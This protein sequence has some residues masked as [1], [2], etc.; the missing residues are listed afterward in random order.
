MKNYFNFTVKARQMVPYFFYMIVLVFGIAVV[1]IM[2]GLGGVDEM[3]TVDGDF[4]IQLLGES[5][6]SLLL[7]IGIMLLSLNMLASILK[8]IV[9][10]EQPF[11]PDF[12][13]KA[14]LW[15]VVKGTLLSFIT[16]GIY[17][18]WYIASIMRYFADNT[19]HGFN[20]I[21]FRGKGGRLFSITVLL[22]ILPLFFSIMLISVG[23][24]AASLG[25]AGIGALLILIAIIAMV[26]AITFYQ[27]YYYKW[28]LDF[29]Y[30]SRRVVLGCK[31][32]ALFWTLLGETVL[33]MITFGI[34]LPM[35][36]LRIYRAFAREIVVGD[37]FIE[38]R[39]GMSLRPWNDWA[40]CWGQ[41]L[42]SV[43]TCWIY[44]PWAV[45][46]IMRRFGSRL[47]FKTIDRPTETMPE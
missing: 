40:Y 22:L 9:Y 29:T 17:T 25:N 23:S 32:G 42:L 15:L 38:A 12:D 3:T 14:W 28:Y 13:S 37:K 43:I 26:V 7:F 36:I 31:P 5:L 18:P 2:L 30:G 47:Y 33:A 46:R 27:I 4:F 10:K 19:M 16:L 21:S 41:I 45:M 34:Y 8:T 6:L 24:G 39:G 11:E 1:A 44:S 20:R 35:A